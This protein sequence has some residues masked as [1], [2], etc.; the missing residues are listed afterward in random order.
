[1]SLLLIMI[2]A[3]PLAFVAYLYY[4]H[5]FERECLALLD[6]GSDVACNLLSTVNPDA[7]DA[8][9]E[10]ALVKR[11]SPV[12]FTPEH[13]RQLLAVSRQ[14]L[15][16]AN[17]GAAPPVASAADDIDFMRCALHLLAS[18][19]WLTGDASTFQ[20]ASSIILMPK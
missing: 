8:L 5:V 13:A 16:L 6:E 19:Q 9:L 17:K 7:L 20:R 2:I 11:F 1:M 4:R 10:H 18:R 15:G 12:P 14:L 3:L